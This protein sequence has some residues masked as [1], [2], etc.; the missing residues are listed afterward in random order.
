MG[1][2]ARCGAPGFVGAGGIRAS[3]Q[4][5]VCPECERR[6]ARVDGR[7]GAVLMVAVVGLDLLVSPAARVRIP[8]L[9]ALLAVTV[10]VHEAGHALAAW[11]LGF[12][13]RVLRIGVPVL[14]R[15]RVGR[16]RVELGPFPFGG[17]VVALTQDPRAYRLRRGTMVAAGPLANVGL[18]VVAWRVPGVVPAA[19]GATTAVVAQLLI[20]GANLW[21]HR[22]VTPD[23]PVAT[24]G[25]ALLD[26]VR[27]KAEAVPAM[28]A[29]ERL[30]AVACDHVHGTGDR[31]SSTPAPPAVAPRR[32]D[33]QPADGATAL[34]L[35]QAAYLSRDLH[36]AVALYEHALATG[37][38]A[39]RDLAMAANDLAWVTGVELRDAAQHARADALSAQSF[40]LMGWHP[41]V[42]NTR[43][44]VLVLVGRA[45]EGVELL[46]AT[47]DVIP[48][49]ASKGRCLAVLAE[50]QLALGDLFAA[51][52]TVARALEAAPGLPEVA[53]VHAAFVAA[54]RTRGV[55][56]AL[57]ERAALA[58]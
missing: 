20:A 48:T 27:A 1:T 41:A 23:G 53:A 38:L 45:A 55:P 24:D 57:D 36:G 56:D 43:G 58:S 4:G 2:C 26:L 11:A 32:S 37:S 19:V 3:R 8:G 10:V 22:A 49:A 13:V 54:A 34:R 47:V 50:G 51:R 6:R 16:T 39:P 25:A 40:A 21:P 15:A 12:R 52:R 46:A 14:A 28:L 17:F 44:A 30:A 5:L 7:R 9:F 31:A 18:A 35:A 29:T 42:R 33:E